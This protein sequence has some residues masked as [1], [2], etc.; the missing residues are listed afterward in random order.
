MQLSTHLHL[1]QLIKCVVRCRCTETSRE[2][3]VRIIIFGIAARTVKCVPNILAGNFTRK[4]FDIVAAVWCISPEFR[5]CDIHCPIV[6][7]NGTTKLPKAYNNETIQAQQYQ[8]S[9]EMKHLKN[10][11]QQG[12]VHRASSLT[13]AVFPTNLHAVISTVPPSL[14]MAPPNCQTYNNETIVWEQERN[15]LRGVCDLVGRVCGRVLPRMHNNLLCTYSCV[16]ISWYL[17]IFESDAIKWDVTGASMN[18][19]KSAIRFGIQN[20][21]TIRTCKR[22]LLF[23]QIK[24]LLKLNFPRTEFNVTITIDDGIFEFNKICHVAMNG[25]WCVG[26][27]RD[28]WGFLDKTC[29]SIFCNG[30]MAIGSDE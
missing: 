24:L 2:I 21:T 13:S 1:N 10:C 18:F 6:I 16:P 8:V 23:T 30:R 22:Q 4:F 27:F 9:F 5:S 28:L 7:E 29:L 25:W 11:T 15:Q 12:Y 20:T 26:R 17:P 19:K 3:T 14:E